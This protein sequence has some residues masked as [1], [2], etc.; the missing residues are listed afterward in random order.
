M[1]IIYI[2][3]IAL[4]L[5][6]CVSTKPKVEEFS[7]DFNSP[8]IAVGEA[9]IQ[10]DRFLSLGSLRKIKAAV[11]YVPIED[12]V[13]LQ[14]R[15]ELTT[16]YQYWSREGREAFA[17]ALVKYNEDYLERRLIRRPRQTRAAY[18]S[19]RGYLI[20]QFQKFSIR[21]RANTD[22]D[23]GYVFKDKFPYFI[24]YQDEAEYI[25]PVGRS[26]NRT[27]PITTMYFTRAQAEELAG[28]FDQ[29]FLIDISSPESGRT[30]ITGESEVD[31]Y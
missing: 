16:F 21:A 22:I 13:C 18:G 11:S 27:S 20:W 29:N 28:F 17:N 5:S 14:Y 23:L 26:N 15:T 30:R 31:E 4:A 2:T 6:A 9:T 12:A 3:L 19:I 10:V 24:I 8:R 7:V 1:K 25:D